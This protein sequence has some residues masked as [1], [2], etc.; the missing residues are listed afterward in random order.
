MRLLTLLL[1][2]LATTATAAETKT[3]LPTNL[4]NGASIYVSSTKRYSVPVPTG[5]RNVPGEN[6]GLRENAMFHPTPVQGFA[7]NIV[8]IEEALSAKMKLSEMTDGSLSFMEKNMPGFKATERK[9]IKNA[10]GVS[11]ERVKYR[12]RILPNGMSSKNVAYF[13]PLD[14]NRLLT[15]TVSGIEATPDGQ[16]DEADTAI[17][18]LSLTK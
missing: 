15:I 4:E 18:K 8:F 14:D 1:L 17:A 10:N 7:C 9:E 2:V 5:W 11:M 16:A 12:A 3:R 13:V 6:I